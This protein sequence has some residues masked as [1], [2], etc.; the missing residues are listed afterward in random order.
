MKL[1]LEFDD[2]GAVYELMDSI[3][4]SHL[5]STKKSLQGYDPRTQADAEYDASIIAAIDV[6][7]GYFGV[8]TDETL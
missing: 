3:V 1:T 4:M 6:L 5:K 2:E 7:V 8:A